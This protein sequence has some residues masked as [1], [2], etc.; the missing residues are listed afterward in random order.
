MKDVEVKEYEIVEKNKNGYKI[1]IICPVCG[2]TI[3][4]ETPVLPEDSD[5][6]I[7]AHCDKCNTDLYL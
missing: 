7:Y 1:K 6:F 2:N 5:D 4:F 3:V